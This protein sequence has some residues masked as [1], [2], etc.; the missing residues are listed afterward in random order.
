VH[1]WGTWNRNWNLL[2]GFDSQ[3]CG[4]ETRG[5]DSDSL[6]WRTYLASFAFDSRSKG[7]Y[8]KP[9]TL[10]V[11]KHNM[12]QRKHIWPYLIIIQHRN[13]GK[14]GQIEGQYRVKIEV[15][16]APSNDS[17]GARYPLASF[18]AFVSFKSF[19]IAHITFLNAITCGVNPYSYFEPTKDP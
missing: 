15:Y 7:G 19:Y 14:W 1:S 17:F 10:N 5:F 16:H 6:K 9:F 4:S 12:H 2:L 13:K 8:T 3:N 11:Y 18:V